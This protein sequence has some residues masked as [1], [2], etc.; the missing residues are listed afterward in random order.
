MHDYFKKLQKNLAIFEQAYL[1]IYFN[2]T[3]FKKVTHLAV[4]IQL[5]IMGIASLI[6]GRQ[7]ADLLF[8]GRHKQHTPEL[9]RYLYRMTSL[10][11]SGVT[12][13]HKIV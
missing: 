2:D 10:L 3:V 8:V 5:G 4:R 9:L 6:V 1:F 11:L 13:H 12:P 7:V